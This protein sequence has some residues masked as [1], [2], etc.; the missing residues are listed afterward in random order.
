MK[1]C[2]QER[3]VLCAGANSKMHMSHE[4]KQRGKGKGIF[5]L[6]SS[7]LCCL[8][9]GLCSCVHC[10]LCSSSMQCFMLAAGWLWAS[11]IVEI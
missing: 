5:F 4:T 11:E 3:Q 10:V 9:V 1:N 2:I 8:A 7:P 6:F